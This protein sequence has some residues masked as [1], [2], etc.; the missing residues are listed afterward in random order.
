MAVIFKKFVPST[1]WDNL[2]IGKRLGRVIRG[3][4]AS[5][6]CWSAIKVESVERQQEILNGIGQKCKHIY[7]VRIL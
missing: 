1:S 2:E 3:E 7:K 4:R 6:L 5:Y